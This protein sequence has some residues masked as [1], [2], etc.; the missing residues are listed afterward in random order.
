VR[1][2]QPELVGLGM[3]LEEAWVSKQTGD[4][5]L[6]DV[7]VSLGDQREKVW[8][9]KAMAPGFGADSSGLVQVGDIVIRVD[10]QYLSG[11]CTT[12]HHLKPYLVRDSLHLDHTQFQLAFL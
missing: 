3:L 2:P 10:G 11:T 6:S 5:T 9:I 4:L 12:L 7:F 8:R 1:A